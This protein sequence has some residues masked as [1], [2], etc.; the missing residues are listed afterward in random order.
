M[1]YSMLALTALLAGATTLLTA[2]QPVI[3][4]KEDKPGLLAT[5]K[6]RSDSAIKLAQARIPNATIQSAEIE[7]EDGR[8]IY[9]FDMKTVG[10]SGIDEVN[11]D[12]NTGKV[13]P[14][15]HE[16]PKAEARERAAD[17]TKAKKKP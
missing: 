8:L 3:T 14:V 12:A 13:L 4:I 10:R 7:N 11:V 1:R 16:G 6:I 9:S 15:E 17:S 2:Q 5:A